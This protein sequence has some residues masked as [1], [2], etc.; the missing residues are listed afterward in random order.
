[1]RTHILRFGLLVAITMV[2]GG[3][4]MRPPP[5]GSTGGGTIYFI[6]GAGGGYNTNYM[7]SMTS[8]GSNVT[9][10]GF[11]GHFNVPSRAHHNGYRWYLTTLSIPNEFYGDEITQRVEVFALRSDFDSVLNNTIDTKVQLTNSST[12]QPAFGWFQGMHWSPGD[13][14][15]SFKARRWMDAVP[16][17]GGLYTVDLVFGADGNIVGITAE[18]TTPALAFPL[19]G[20]E[21]PTFGRHSWGLSS[22]QVAYIDSPETGLWVADLST[23]TRTRIYSG[24][25]GYLDWSQDGTKI[26][27]GSGTIRT[28]RPSG[29]GL[30]TVLGPRYV[31]NVWVS[32]FA[33]AYFSPTASNITCVGVM[34]LAGGGQDNDVIRATSNGGSVTNL[35]NTPARVELP[36]GWR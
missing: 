18:P 3:A 4:A 11:W 35:T 30:R 32:G 33:H 23:G 34:N 24:G 31:N 16:V 28:I 9:Q 2:L 27:F 5:D 7:W 25:V 19:D 21:W 20:S 15:V 36:V 12:L 8:S 6:N 26:V 10:L 29:T 1:M 13:L 22:T 14:K 17:E